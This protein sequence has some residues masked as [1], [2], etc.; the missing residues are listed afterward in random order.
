LIPFWILVT[1]G[2]M[3]VTTLWEGCF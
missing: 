2:N 3:L 1:K